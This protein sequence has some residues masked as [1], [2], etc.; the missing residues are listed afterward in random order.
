MLF[1]SMVAALQDWDGVFFF[2]YHSSE[3]GWDTDRLRGYFSLNGQPVKLALLA[4]CANLY[5]RGDLK[6]LPDAAAGTL[7]DLLPATLGLDHRIGIDPKATLPAGLAAPAGKRLASPDG[8]L[9]WDADERTRAHLVINTPNSRAVWGLIAGQ[10]FDLGGVQLTLGATDRNYAALV[11]TSLDGKPLEKA[12]R[13]LL[14]AVG[15]AQNQGMV[16]NNTRTSVGNN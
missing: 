6:P 14:T 2:D 8:R 13:I 12:R 3:N 16:W 15:S 10:K 4:A 9:V 11:L 1:R 7:R 5:R